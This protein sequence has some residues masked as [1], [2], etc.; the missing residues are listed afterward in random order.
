[1][2]QNYPLVLIANLCETGPWCTVVLISIPVAWIH[3]DG[4][5]QIRRFIFSPWTKISYNK[6]D[7][8]LQ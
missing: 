6:R 5:F 2:Y 3:K 7:P 8:M 4:L 1:M